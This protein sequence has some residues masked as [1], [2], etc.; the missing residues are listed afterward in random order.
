MNATDPQLLPMSLSTP[1]WLRPLMFDQFPEAISFQYGAELDRNQTYKEVAFGE[2]HDVYVDIAQTNNEGELFLMNFVPSRNPG[3]A[4]AA[5]L[6]SGMAQ[7]LNNGHRVT[8]L[9]YYHL[10]PGVSF[11]PSL[12]E[13]RIL[14]KRKLFRV[15]HI[16][17]DIHKVIGVTIKHS[18]ERK[19]E[20]QY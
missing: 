20:I 19:P 9:A 10:Q 6:L 5:R 12:G 7:A 3:V 11:I 17:E 18:A 4:D 14:A 1:S 8:R 16:T 2:S 13:A 15:T